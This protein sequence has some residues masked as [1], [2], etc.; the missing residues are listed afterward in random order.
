MAAVVWAQ[1]LMV[2]LVVMGSNP[3]IAYKL[4]FVVVYASPVHSQVYSL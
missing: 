4:V 2:P 3:D 1:R